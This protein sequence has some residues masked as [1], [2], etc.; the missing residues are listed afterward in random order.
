[1]LEQ[2]ENEDFDNLHLVLGF[3]KEKDVK[4][5]FEILPKKAFYYLCSPIIERGLDLNEL[6]DIAKS[7]NINFKMYPSVKKALASAKFNSR[8]NDLIIISGSTFVVAEIM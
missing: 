1:M 8:H 6:S 4:A 7:S 5:I 3:V 2:L